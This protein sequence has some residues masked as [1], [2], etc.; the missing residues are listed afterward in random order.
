MRLGD[1]GTAV[2][3]KQPPEMFYKSRMFLKFPKIHKK[4]PVPE[5]LY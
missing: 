4:V 1:N 3:Q 2:I 5:S